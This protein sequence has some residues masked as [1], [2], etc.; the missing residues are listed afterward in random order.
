MNMRKLK[1]LITPIERTMI[2]SALESYGVHDLAAGILAR[3]QDA[4]DDGPE[5]EILRSPLCGS[6]LES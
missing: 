3:E 6:L 5:V 2:I 4:A 1:L